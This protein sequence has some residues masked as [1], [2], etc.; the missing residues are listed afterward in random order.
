MTD[1]QDQENRVE[2]LTPPQKTKKPNEVNSLHIEGFV[3]IHDPKT[4]EVY[5][6]SRA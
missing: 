2:I 1:K 4:K 5:L 6:E 3:K